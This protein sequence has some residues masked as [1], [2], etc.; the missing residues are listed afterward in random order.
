MLAARG[1]AATAERIVAAFGL[2]ELEEVIARVGVPPGE[3]AEVEAAYRDLYY[4]SY[5]HLAN[6]EPLSG[7]ED[8]IERL[9]GAAVPLALVTNRREE[10][11]HRALH[12][13]G[14]T[15]HFPVVV[16]RDTV[17]EMNPHPAPALHALAALGGA[18]HQAA[19]V[20]DTAEDMACARDAAIATVV[21][22]THDRSAGE[23]RAAGATHVAADLAEV[24]ALLG[25]PLSPGDDAR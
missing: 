20:G 16:G 24:A 18:A 3:A 5:V 12:A 14:W 1:L 25:G 9:T 6:A 10:S 21:G 7:A 22:L 17:E 11:A 19:F 23:L 4:G 8:L 13:R 2:P 15:E